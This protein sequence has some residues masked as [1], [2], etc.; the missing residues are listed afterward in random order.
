MSEALGAL[1]RAADKL[2]D[3][4]RASPGARERPVPDYL[5]RAAAAGTLKR[6]ARWR[7]VLI[8]ADAIAH[9]HVEYFEISGQLAVLH[10]CVFHKV[11]YAFPIFGFDVI[12]GAEKATGAFLDLSPAGPETA[13]I[14]AEWA[15]VFAGSRAGFEKARA[16]PD[17]GDIFSVEA[18]AVRP[19]DGGEIEAAL[20]LG[21]ASLSWLLSQPLALARDRRRVAAGQGAY[22]AGQRR[23]QH[24]LRVLAGVVGEALARDFVETWLFPSLAPPQAPANAEAD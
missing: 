15:N 24:T 3:Q 16:L 11:D 18:L 10:A 1:E 12:T 7:N 4:V 8:E 9:A 2:A 17:W 22:I 6:P 21:Q 23:N 13:H 5:A 20:A 19:R 14:V